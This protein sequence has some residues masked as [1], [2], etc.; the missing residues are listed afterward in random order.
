MMLHRS[1]RVLAVL[2]GALL[3]MHGAAVAQDSPP[4]RTQP[5]ST[6]PRQPSTTPPRVLES[7]RT[8]TEQRA[9]DLIACKH[10]IGEDVLS[11]SGDDIGD[12]S[13]LLIATKPGRIQYV[14]V[15]RGGVAGLGDTL[16][17][18]PFAAFR[19]N[20]AEEKIMLPVSEDQIKNAPK[21]EGTDWRVL[22]QDDRARQIHAYYAIDD[23]DLRVYKRYDDRDWGH[24][25]DDAVLQRWPLLKATDVRGQT[26]MSDEGS[27]LGTIKDIVIDKNSGRIAFAVVSFGGTLGLGDKLV[28]IPWDLF[29]VN[30][31]GKVYATKIDKEQLK[32]APRLESDDWD[33]FD[34]PTYIRSQYKHFGRDE[35]WLTTSARDG[36]MDRDH[37]RS[38]PTG[39]PSG[40]HGEDAPYSDYDQHFAK[41]RK[42]DLI[43]VV[44]NVTTSSAGNMPKIVLISVDANDKKGVAAHL[45]PE[46]YLKEHGIAVKP[47]DKV[48]LHGRWCDVE[49]K[50]CFLVA[51]IEPASGETVLIRQPDGTR[52]WK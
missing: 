35:A 18:V 30:N 13:N 36:D 14:V 16:Y 44:T 51:T 31:E 15:S 38:D 48:T 20:E 45:A 3:G 2:A 27:E 8:T 47:G 28:A 5:P 4:P 43:G 23:D 25:R 12:V 7:E 19:C 33:E 40:V 17:A 22:S 37:A 34:N 50:E 10:I 42:G 6:P 46:A 26:L 32:A 29:D 52:D 41:G 49:G 1:T 9:P 24:R 21:L 11:S 39:R